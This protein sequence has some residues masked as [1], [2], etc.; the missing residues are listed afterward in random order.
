MGKADQQKEEEKK[1]TIQQPSEP[2]E[3]KLIPRVPSER[4]EKLHEGVEKKTKGITK[5]LPE[6][7]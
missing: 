4:I 6:N 2:V 5:N 3:R 7:G 1:T